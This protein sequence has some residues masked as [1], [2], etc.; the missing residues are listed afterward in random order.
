[1]ELIG[2]IVGSPHKDT[3]GNNLVTVNIGKSEKKVHE[4][5][6]NLYDKNLKIKMNILKEKRSDNA[7]RLFWKCVY[8]L[9][10]ALH[11]DNWDQYLMEL[12]RYGKYTTLIVRQ[13]AYQDFINM[14]RETKIVGERKDKD[15]VMYYDVNC[16]YGSS[17]YDTAEFA[18]L[19]DGVMK[20]M[21]DA[22]ISIPEM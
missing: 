10:D 16:F 3:D 14:W 18:R 4:L 15:G 17:T 5:Y 7:N 20:D 22:G 19:L 11:N 6:N 2:R 9:A 1:M 13:D 8:L 21:E 12:E